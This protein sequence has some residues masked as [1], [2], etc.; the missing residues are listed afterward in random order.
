MGA[1]AHLANHEVLHELPQKLSKS[2]RAL[3]VWQIIQ[4]TAKTWQACQSLVAVSSQSRRQLPFEK[5]LALPSL[6]ASLSPQSAYKRALVRRSLFKLPPVPEGFIQRTWHMPQT[7]GLGPMPTLEQVAAFTRDLRK[8]SSPLLGPWAGAGWF[9]RGNLQNYVR[10]GGPIVMYGM[11]RSGSNTVQSLLRGHCGIEVFFSETLKSLLLFEPFLPRISRTHANLPEWKHFRPWSVPR[12]NAT[13]VFERAPNASWR[14]VASNF[15]VVEERRGFADIA[16]PSYVSQ[17]AQ[18]QSLDDLEGLVATSLC[19][20][21][22]VPP[23]VA[24]F[25]HGPHPSLAARPRA[26]II[27]VR[28]P[29]AWL[30]SITHKCPD[31]PQPVRGGLPSQVKRSYRYWVHTWNAHTKSWLAMAAQSLAGGDERAI[32]VRNE[33]IVLDCADTVQK[34]AAALG[35][36]YFQANPSSDV[37]PFQCQVDNAGPIRV[38]MSARRSIGGAVDVAGL[39]RTWMASL[40]KYPQALAAL[41][42]AD[43]SAMEALGYVYPAMLGFVNVSYAL[44]EMLWEGINKVF[45]DRAQPHQ[46]NGSSVGGRTLTAPNLSSCQ[47]WNESKLLMSVP[48]SWKT[49][50]ALTNLSVEDSAWIKQRR[51]V[52]WMDHAW[53]RRAALGAPEN[54][55]IQPGNLTELAL[56]RSQ[57]SDDSPSILSSGKPRALMNSMQMT[58]LLE[59]PQHKQSQPVPQLPKKAA[60]VRVAMA[61]LTRDNC[62]ALACSTVMVDELA[63]VGLALGFTVK[64][65]I[66][67]DGSR[68]CSPAAI[69]AWQQRTKKY[70]VVVVPSQG[71][72]ELNWQHDKEQYEH[73]G[74]E[75]FR[76]QRYRGM[77]SRRQ[78]LVDT[79]A[80]DK[81]FGAT[82][83]VQYDSDL[84]GGWTSHRIAQAVLAASSKQ[85]DAICANAGDLVH[86]VR[87]MHFDTLALRVA[88]FDAQPGRGFEIAGYGDAFD[89]GRLRVASCFGGLAIYRA[90]IFAECRYQTVELPDQVPDCEHVQLA[91]CI[92][93]HGRSMHL[94][95]NLLIK[96]RAG[97]KR[98]RGVP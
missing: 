79:I 37:Y 33:D 70:E 53:V 88:D 5:A 69:Q 97:Q 51:L 84:S 83:I 68:D 8:H 61:T 11:Q 76:S 63:D 54:K 65:Y 27:C 21:S 6:W 77:A 34:I 3:H 57:S 13:H 18:V 64:V 30:S 32:F 17:A 23:T 98:S 87:W 46:R 78:R 10:A 81:D 7:K 93:A 43:A 19:E 73:F 96:G 91:R 74:K 50:Y 55:A 36:L 14:T 42:E 24:G 58:T 26:Y 25:C 49:D 92:A 9:E 71:L 2:G 38:M 66:L 52:S 12:R 95:P 15:S 31:C 41:K 45:Q 47:L 85:Y 90:Q 80:A 44:A 72:P 59:Q 1:A 82:T 75:L 86:G 29:M 22:P 28:H 67:E 40:I 20:R 39:T 94:F 62:K 16:M 48:W 89:S 35:L 4:L 56:L 60:A